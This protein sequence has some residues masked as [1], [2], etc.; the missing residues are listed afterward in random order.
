MGLFD[1][2]MVPCPSCGRDVEFQSKGGD[3][4]MHRFPLVS[5]PLDVL[6]GAIRWNPTRC[7]CGQ[8][9]EIVS[10][11]SRMAR[12]VPTEEVKCERPWSAGRDVDFVVHTCGDCDWCLA[13]IRAREED[14]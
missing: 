7:P 1:S 5:A 9:V 12:A 13:A 11:M 6:V 8:W 2:V 4:L 14:L 10:R 3:C